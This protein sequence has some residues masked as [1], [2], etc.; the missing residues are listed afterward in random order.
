MKMLDHFLDTKNS[1]SHRSRP[2][3]KREDERE[4]D[5]QI[6]VIPSKSLLQQ[7]TRGTK[8]LSRGSATSQR[9]TYVLVVEV[10]T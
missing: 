2:N 9:S 10:T 3:P 7:Q 5:K 8:D 6:Q 4:R 1:P